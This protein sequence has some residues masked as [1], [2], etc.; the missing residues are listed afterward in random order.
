MTMNDNVVAFPAPAQ[1]IRMTREKF[2]AAVSAQ[3]KAHGEKVERVNDLINAAIGNGGETDSDVITSACLGAF[4]DEMRALRGDEDEQERIMKYA[5]EFLNDWKDY[6]PRTSRRMT[7]EVG[8]QLDALLR[9]AIE[10]HG[11][12]PDEVIA[13]VNPDCRLR[14]DVVKTHDWVCQHKMVPIDEIWL[15]SL[16]SDEIGIGTIRRRED[17][18]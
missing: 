10:K 3:A 14:E 7:R 13:F 5:L 4:M 8:G 9:L 17:D 18:V 16:E 2:E 6:V 12:P 11:L 1:Q 15:T